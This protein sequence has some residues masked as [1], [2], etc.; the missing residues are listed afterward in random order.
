MK[1]F[2]ILILDDETFNNTSKGW[3]RVID[4]VLGNRKYLKEPSEV[5]LEQNSTKLR[6]SE[7]LDI[8]FYQPIKYSYDAII[9]KLS[10]NDC[11]VQSKCDIFFVDIDWKNSFSKN[12]SDDPS[13]QEINEGKIPV[14]L[15]GL[16]ILNVLVKN[17]KPKIVFSGSDKTESARKLFKLLDKRV[18]TDD[19]LIGE[20]TGAGENSYVNEVEAKIDTYLQ[21]RQIAIIN[22]QPQKLIKQL[23]D[24]V[25]EW[26]SGNV[27]Q[28]DEP[29]IPDDG[30]DCE[31]KES[32]WSL[33]TL[34]PKQVNR[35]E[36]GIDVEENK[37]YILNV[38]NNFN[39]P[40]IIYWL[41]FDH[42]KN[43]NKTIDNLTEK[44]IEDRLNVLNQIDFPIISNKATAYQKLSEIEGVSGFPE[45][46]NT[47][48]MNA[49]TKLRETIATKFCPSFT[50]KMTKNNG[51]MT[52]TSTYSTLTSEEVKCFA[53]YGVY[54][55][56]VVFIQKIA[57]ANKHH[58]S[59]SS[60]TTNI[61]I[62]SGEMTI[63]YVFCNTNGVGNINGL[64]DKINAYFNS[65]RYFGTFQLQQEGIEDLLEIMCKRYKAEG[66][67]Q[68]GNQSVTLKR[69]TKAECETSSK[70]SYLFKFK[71]KN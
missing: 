45:I 17:D 54:V 33:R 49:L 13:L 63:E 14:H 4:Y 41:L 28:A 47:C 70:V 67:I 57:D 5:S 15:A 52:G 31:N 30:K 46:L 7:P 38:L 56:D 10:E 12:F 59:A 40:A 55:G 60:I 53:E 42:G 22:C 66:K 62:E 24:I 37:D 3:F 61:V 19:I 16:N 43:E 35:I 23:S 58:C 36:L 48:R 32:C 51:A 20:L 64:V 26:N 6:N 65:E 29:L 68:I 69:D 44:E 1:K 50:F 11:A 21:S 39:F 9:E 2:K 71:S 34:F 27:A 8:F 18:L 25:K